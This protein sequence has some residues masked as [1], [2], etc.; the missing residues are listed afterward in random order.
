MTRHDP[1]YP[2]PQLDQPGEPPIVFAWGAQTPDDTELL[3]EELDLWVIWLVDRYRLDHRVVPDCWTRHP[4]LIEELS[5]LHLAWQGSFATTS[6][7]DAPLQWHERFA[8]A[9]ER[10]ND[11][12]ARTGCRPGN[13][14][15]N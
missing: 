15:G 11:W 10:L 8:A 6:S 13:H 1:F 14:R 5:A 7:A 4:E 2:P 9:R 3:I 12:V